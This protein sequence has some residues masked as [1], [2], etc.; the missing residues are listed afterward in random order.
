MEKFNNSTVIETGLS[1]HHELL[2]LWRVYAKAIISYTDYKYFNQ[3]VTRYWYNY[4]HLLRKGMLGL[5]TLL[6]IQSYQRLSWLDPD[7]VT[8]FLRTLPKKHPIIKYR[9]Y[10]TGL[11]RKWKKS[12]ISISNSARSGKQLNLFSQIKKIPAV[13]KLP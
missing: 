13:I 9:N 5:T 12:L 6:W 2:R 8:S 3:H 11:F 1:D 10:W 4:M 7:F